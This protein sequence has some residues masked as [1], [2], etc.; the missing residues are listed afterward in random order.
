[1]PRKQVNGNIFTIF[2]LG[3]KVKRHFSQGGGSAMAKGAKESGLNKWLG[4]VLE[5]N[6]TLQECP[7]ALLL[8]LILV[9]IAILTTIASNTAVVAIVTPVLLG[10]VITPLKST[11]HGRTKQLARISNLVALSSDYFPHQAYVKGVHPQYLVL[12]ATTAASYA[13]VL[14]VSTPPNAIVYSACPE[15]RLQDMAI[16]GLVINL[17]SLLVLFLTTNTTSSWFLGFGGYN[18]ECGNMTRL[19]SLPLSLI[20]P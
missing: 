6:E 10:M 3:L 14:P 5:K 13:F 8:L 19:G 11:K 18:G 2:V 9:M 15:L 12:A 7:D 4:S 1:M 16:P 17:V 20:M